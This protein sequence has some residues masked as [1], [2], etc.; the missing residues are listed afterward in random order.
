MG[1]L[2]NG[3]LSRS[4]DVGGR[5]IRQQKPRLF[6]DN[7]LA[8]NN[9]LQMG[10]SV[11]QPPRVLSTCLPSLCHQDS[12]TTR[13]ISGSVSHGESC[14]L[15]PAFARILAEAS[16][17][18]TCPTTHTLDF[19]PNSSTVKI[20]LKFCCLFFFFFF[21]E[22]FYLF[23]KGKGGE[24]GRETLMCKRNINW[25]PFACTQLGTLPVT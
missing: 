11:P 22:R 23:L 2:H 6:G 8:P 15:G 10:A 24:R 17:P 14:I 3:R 9:E 18:R 7:L 12:W 25:L 16:P 20:Q 21:S 13:Q 5:D 19:L 1:S 4:G